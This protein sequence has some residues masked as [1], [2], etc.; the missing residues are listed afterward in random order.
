MT[1]IR[2]ARKEDMP[3]VMRFVRELA[4]CEGLGHEVVATAESMSRRLFEERRAKV[5]FCCEDGEAVGFAVYYPT[6]STW[7][8]RGG[9]YV[10][11]LYVDEPYRKKGYG[12]ALLS[13][14]AGI[15]KETG[16][17]RVEW[18][19]MVANRSGREF[20]GRLGAT[21]LDDRVVFRLSGPDLDRLSTT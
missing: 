1:R 17:A 20:Y 19:C 5:L 11:D 16:C 4:C 12:K 10:E 14:I 7:E 13:H 3:L 18:S 6:F 15:A 8:G 9:L 21:S 2:E